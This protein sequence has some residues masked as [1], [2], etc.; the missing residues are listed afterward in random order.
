MPTDRT[1]QF[2]PSAE[3]LE[4]TGA[5]RPLPAQ[6]RPTSLTGRLV[7]VVDRVRQL[8][9][10]LGL[11][12]YRVFL[13][14]LSWPGRKGIGQPQVLSER[15]ILPT[16]KVVDMSTTSLFLRAAG[17][18]EEGSIVVGE[19]SPKYSEDDLMGLTPDLTS[20]TD[21]MTS[22]DNVEFFWEI[23]ESRQV[24]PAP[25][26]RRYVPSGVP[27]LNLK[28]SEWRVPLTKQDGNRARG[29]QV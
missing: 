14:H 7:Q 12:P 9:T 8:N 15:E 23:R 6:Q 24:F 1:T 26:P 3:L 18:G 19:I 29:G 22:S 17:L 4:Q 5:V 27:A 2:Q 28:K 13:V 21:P 11:R 20:A 16:P 25:Q 10:R